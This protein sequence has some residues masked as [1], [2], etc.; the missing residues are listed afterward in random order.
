LQRPNRTIFTNR[1][2]QKPVVPG[3]AVGNLNTIANNPRG[4][5]LN[6]ADY[7]GTAPFNDYAFDVSQDT[8][9]LMPNNTGDGLA[10]GIGKNNDAGKWQLGTDGVLT[11]GRIGADNIITRKFAN[12]K[13]SKDIIDQTNSAIAGAPVHSVGASNN[14][15]WGELIDGALMNNPVVDYIKKT[16]E[17]IKTPNYSH[18]IKTDL[19]QLKYTVR[20]LMTEVDMAKMT[21]GPGPQG[22]TSVAQIREIDGVTMA[23][24]D[25]F[26]AFNVT[27]ENTVTRY[28]TAPIGF[29]RVYDTNGSFTWFDKLFDANYLHGL[30][31]IFFVS[32]GKKY[33]NKYFKIIASKGTPRVLSL[34][35]IV[36]T[37]TINNAADDIYNY[38]DD[39]EIGVLY[40]RDIPRPAYKFYDSAEM[41][42]RYPTLGNETHPYYQKCQKDPY[43][44]DDCYGKPAKNCE[45][46]NVAVFDNDINNFGRFNETLGVWDNRSAFVGNEIDARFIFSSSATLRPGPFR[47]S[48]NMVNTLANVNN[49]FSASNLEY[50]DRIISIINNEYNTII[51][52]NGIIIYSLKP[53]FTMIFAAATNQCH[54]IDEIKLFT[55]SLMKYHNNYYNPNIAEPTS[56]PGKCLVWYKK[57]LLLKNIKNDMT[58]EYIKKLYSLIE[59]LKGIYTMSAVMTEYNAIYNLYNTTKTAINY[60]GFLNPKTDLTIAAISMIISNTKHYLTQYFANQNPNAVITAYYGGG[61]NGVDFYNN[62]SF[63]A[64]VRSFAGEY[65]HY[66]RAYLDI[67]PVKLNVQYSYLDVNRR[68][69]KFSDLH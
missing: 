44:M 38:Q 2:N 67:Q 25:I 46:N 18:T 65:A 4:M 36:E 49:A 68:Q 58:L 40:N 13:Y 51:N 17:K 54:R 59:E 14:G 69:P 63:T 12:N 53:M 29:F 48:R 15:V 35:E 28:P 30:G 52:T 56:V 3:G 10:F 21:F 23:V 66:T 60:N 9:G 50:I 20:A 62:D 22:N 33:G 41:P 32:S 27:K 39:P 19:S 57:F 6:R 64:F 37:E 45:I 11:A 8:F 55:N 34:R 24:G 31:V 47:K 42:L 26:A 16:I 7:V 5:N 43:C 1:N 61:Y